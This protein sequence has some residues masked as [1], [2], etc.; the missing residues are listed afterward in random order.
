MDGIWRGGIAD[1]GCG[2]WNFQTILCEYGEI[3]SF[4]LWS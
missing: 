4:N 1:C 2:V 3:E